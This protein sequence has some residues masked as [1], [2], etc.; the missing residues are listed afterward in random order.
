MKSLTGTFAFKIVVVGA[1]LGLSVLTVRLFGQTDCPDP[2]TITTTYI[3]EIKVPA[4]LKKPVD[5]SDTLENFGRVLNEVDPDGK[6][7]TCVT[8]KVS[9]SAEKIKGPP[10]SNLRT[11]AA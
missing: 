1:V 2:T 4:K 11:S 5:G 8:L 6:N 10:F 9:D 3:L 7:G